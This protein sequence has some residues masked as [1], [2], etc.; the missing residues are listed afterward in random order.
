MEP[1]PGPGAAA[2][3]GPPAPR[4]RRRRSLRRLLR[5]FLLALGSRSRPEDSP[6]RPQPRHCDGD[7]EGGFACAP[8]PTP[9][10]S[11]SPEEERPPGPQPQLPAGDGARPPGAQ[12]LKNHGNTCFMN[13]VVQCLSNTDLLA[14]FLALGR[15]RAAPG[16]AEVTEHLAALVRALW[17]REYT[18][19]LSAEFK[20]AVSK[21][22][23]QFQGN[24]QH[25]ALEFLLWLLDRVHEDLEGSSR[26]PGSEKLQPEASKA[27]ENHLSPSPQPSLGQ[28][29]V[30][31]HFQAQYRSSLTCPHCL[32]QSN[33]FD[34]FLCVSLPIPLRQ[35]RF[36]SI[37]VVFPSKSQRFLRVGL[38][39]PILSTVAALRKMVAEEG[40]VPVDEVILVE[41]SPSGL[42]RSF[43]DEEDLNSI[44]EGDNVYAFQAPPPPGQEILTAHPSGLSVSPRAAACEGQRS[45]PAHQENKVLILF[46]NLVGSGQ[47]ASRF[48]PPFLIR[49]DR[50]I[51]WVQLQQCI[52]SKVRCLMKGEAPEQQNPGSLFSIRVVGQSLA[53]SYL[54][55]QDSRPLCHWAVDRA[56]HLRGPGGPPHVKLAVEWDSGVK[57]RLFGSL[58]EE[59]VRDADSVWRQ[60]QAHQQHSCTLDECFQFYTKEEQLA[61][62]DAWKCPH[63]KALQQGMVKLSLWT[64]PDILIIHLKRFCQVGERR[65]K[66]STLVKFPLCGLNMAPHVARRSAGPAPGAWPSWTQPACLPT[67]Y[68]LDFLYDLYAVCNHHGSLQGGHY[69]AYCRNSLDGQWYSYDDSTVESL[70]EDEVMTRG[71]YI[72]FYQK[73]NSIPSWSASSSMR[74]STSSTLSD[75]WLARL[76]SNDSSTWGSLLSGRS[77]PSPCGPQVPDPPALTNSLSGPENGGLESRPWVRGVRGRS[78]SLK[79]PA[80]SPAKQGPFR[81]MPLRWSFRHREKAPGASAELVEYLE[82]RRRP[83]STS[84]SIVPLLTGAAGEGERSAMPRPGATLSAEGEGSERAGQRVPAAAPCPSGPLG[85]C[86]AP[87]TSDGLSTAGKLKEPAGPDVRLPRQFDLP[88]TV[89]PSVENEQ[90]ARPEG[91]RTASWKGSGQAG[92]SSGAPSPKDA[93]STVAPADTRRNPFARFRAGA[94]WGDSETDRLSQGTL[95]LLRSVFWKKENKKNDKAEVAPQVSPVSLGSGRLSPAVD[96]QARVSFSS[97]RMP[98]G[99]ARGLEGAVRSAPNSLHLPRKASRPTRASALSVAQRSVPGEQ[100]SF[101]TLQKV[102]YHTLSLGRKKT[103]PESSF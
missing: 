65:N 75:H 46:C 40:S 25:D 23:A 21:Y 53:L 35:T 11:G 47:Q 79:V 8:A 48:G 36:L 100:T 67:S 72:L 61:Q 49:E 85:H 39:V 90:R 86:A 13:A 1:E 95:T 26:G 29:F 41:L 54:S 9:A 22:S 76:E 16:R 55:P 64:L 51:S 101:S 38:A 71:A 45:L 15:Y 98:E 34:P 6:P 88:L 50:A 60:Q 7:G 94:E 80:P 66:L 4:P 82:S 77:A 73:R 31:S 30:Q 97:L 103:L 96:E 12:G 37:T 32:R 70:L 43:F 58:Q 14:E 91:Q 74:G 92:G 52:L 18:P 99:L 89:M 44:A 87:G 83:R 93:S 81:T 63:C 2:G 27:S 62:D 5:R 3:G 42:Q 68:P 57:E 59:R 10:A 28:S 102:K 69:T 78:I 17:T 84:Q 20:N 56:L 24:A 19:Q 33:T